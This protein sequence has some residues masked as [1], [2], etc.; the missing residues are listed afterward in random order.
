MHT[1][2]ELALNLSTVSGRK[3]YITRMLVF[4]F[5]HQITVAA[6]CSW[7]LQADQEV[8]VAEQEDLLA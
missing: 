1:V 6:L 7:Q 5:L 8:T 4:E 2:P 3:T